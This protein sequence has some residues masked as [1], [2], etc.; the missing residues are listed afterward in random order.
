MIDLLLKKGCNMDQ[1]DKVSKTNIN[2]LLDLI[3][4]L[5]IFKAKY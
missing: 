2:E 4:T 1:R 3:L 5:L